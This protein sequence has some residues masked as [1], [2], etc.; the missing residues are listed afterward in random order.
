M[1]SAPAG[2][3]SLCDQTFIPAAQKRL[4]SAHSR[5][6]QRGC[7]PGCTRAAVMAPCNAGL[8]TYKASEMSAEDL[9]QATA[10]PRIDFASIL[11]T[12]AIRASAPHAAPRI[13]ALP[14]ATALF[15]IRPQ[16]ESL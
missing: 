15:N 14:E 9:L 12:V 4:Q 1:L 5:G 2:S 13:A 3:A 16:P 11:S 6:R 8:K 7:R 10:R